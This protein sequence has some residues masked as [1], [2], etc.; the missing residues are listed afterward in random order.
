MSKQME[1]SVSHTVLSTKRLV[2]PS[3]WKNGLMNGLRKTGYLVGSMAL[4]VLLWEV[5]SRLSGKALPGPMSTL[6]TFWDLVAHP[7]YNYGPND[8]GIG[9]QFIASLLRVFA[10]FLLGALVAVPLGIVMGATPFFRNLFGPIVQVLRPVSPL[11]WFPIGLAVFHS[12]GPAT[13]FIIFITSLWPTV[14]NT[15][16]G[17]ASVPKD[18]RNVA[19]VFRFSKWKYLTKVLI[20]FSLPYILT[21]LRLSLGI[22]WMV[23]VAAEMLSGGTGIGFFVWDSWNALSLERVISAIVLIGL[24]GLVL[25]RGFHYIE[26]RFNYGG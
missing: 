16:L 20:P 21:G 7:F 25:D 26:K 9:L 6:A 22:A 11:A 10:G 17:V 24:V 23:I 13:I 14:V 5:T 12:V 4:L 1:Q 18:H 2:L 3:H 8:K 15:A 19:A